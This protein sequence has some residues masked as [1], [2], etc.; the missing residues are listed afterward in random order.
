M[1]W[2]SPTYLEDRHGSFIAYAVTCQ[3]E[4]EIPSN[5]RFGNLIQVTIDQLHPFQTYNCCVLLQTTMA[6]STET[7]QQQD[8]SEDGK[9][10]TF[11]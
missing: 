8:T 11:G 7:C 3:S 1:V 10:I 4:Q 6:N 9:F 5:Y 2:N